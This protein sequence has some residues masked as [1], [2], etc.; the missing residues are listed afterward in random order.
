MTTGN[1]QNAGDSSYFIDH[2]SGA[3]MARLIEQDHLL[4]R[5]MGGLLSEQANDFS[6]IH[7]V[8][9]IACGPAGWAL[10]LAFQ[11]PELEIVGIDISQQMIDYA[12]AQ[13]EVRH[14][15]NVQF[16]V[17]DALQ[18]LDL[19]SDA[20]DVVNIRLFGFLAPDAW[21]VLLQ[22]CMRVARAGGTIRLT[23]TEMGVSNSAA[24]EKFT[25]WF[26]HALYR[27][28]QSFSPDGRMFC[29]TAMLGRLLRN[30]G[31][32]QVQYKAHA[33]E[34]VPGTDAHAGMYEDYKFSVKLLQPFFISTGVATQ[35]EQDQNYEQLLVELMQD[36]FSGLHFMV[37]AWGKK[38]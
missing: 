33:I 23:E 17:M 34:F 3:E 32:E 18:P 26:T 10:E 25:G 16:L 4:N 2:E 22:E 37:T 30:A 12:R 27:A 28:G 31:C 5:G 7:Q 20:F 36:D 13:A 35:E 14:L 21:P 9:D 19:P 38:P 8:L 6:G 29:T 11:H 24:L 15:D 1:D